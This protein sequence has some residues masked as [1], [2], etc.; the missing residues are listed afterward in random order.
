MDG[1]V[2]TD[3]FDTA[4]ATPSAGDEQ[5]IVLSPDDFK[6]LGSAIGAPILWQASLGDRLV[7]SK[8]MM[9][10]FGS[11]ERPA[12]AALATGM[13][14]VALE[15]ID[16]LVDLID[17]PGLPNP[18]PEKTERLK[19]TIHKAVA[20]LITMDKTYDEHYVADGA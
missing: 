19:A 9:S 18:D 12:S 5:T 10:R 15:K 1:A 6:R 13:R 7:Y 2:M 14:R 8:S 3:D 20:Q 16:Q 17:L 11:G 4:T